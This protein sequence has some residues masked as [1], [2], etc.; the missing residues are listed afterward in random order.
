MQR[1]FEADPHVPGHALC[2]SR[3]A[4]PGRHRFIPMRPNLLICDPTSGR[5]G[6]ADAGLH[7]A[8]HAGP[9]SPAASNGRYHVMVTNAGGGYSRWKELAVT[10]W[11]EDA[12]RDSWGCSAISA[13]WTSGD[14]WSAAYQP[15]LKRPT[16]R[17]DFP[18]G[19][20]P[21]SGAGISTSTIAHR[22][23]RLA[24]RRHRSPS[25]DDHQPFAARP[26]RWN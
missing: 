8:Q 24:G 12:T 18:A 4:F 13:T 9:G 25:A 3:S 5:T 2:C 11:R 7:R 22:N 15:T 21:N 26:G 14:V 10:R 6:N 16:L 19:P 17:S 20:R 23:R 1:R